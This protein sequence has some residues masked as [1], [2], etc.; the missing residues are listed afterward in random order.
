MIIR[1]R[2][3]IRLA[4]WTSGLRVGAVAIF[5]FIIVPGGAP[6]GE[7]LI[8]HEKIHLRQQL[9]L[10]IIPFYI[11][12]AISFLRKGYQNVSFE[13]E[14]YQNEHDPDY[15]RKRKAYSFLRYL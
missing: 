11:W 10:L 15:L 9:E 6:P 2:W 13:K 7:S 8:N 14:A 12:Y 4:E 1:S 3:F 5:P